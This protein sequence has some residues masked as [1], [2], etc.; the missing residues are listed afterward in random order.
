MYTYA[1]VLFTPLPLQACRGLTQSTLAVGE[2]KTLFPL[3]LLV[4][5]LYCIAWYCFVWY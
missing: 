1:N 3:Y 5:Q 2:K 4:M